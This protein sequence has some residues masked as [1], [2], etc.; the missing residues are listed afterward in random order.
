MKSQMTRSFEGERIDPPSTRGCPDGEKLTDG[1][2]RDIVSSVAG[3]GLPDGQ[4]YENGV[5]G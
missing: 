3:D 2:G 1:D 4:Y 5:L